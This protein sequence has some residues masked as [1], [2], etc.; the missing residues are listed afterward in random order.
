MRGMWIHLITAGILFAVCATG[1][2]AGTSLGTDWTERPPTDSPFSGVQISTDGS[3]VFAGGNQMLVRNW[4]GDSHF[5]GRAG[6][7][8]S[9]SPDGNYVVVA[10]GA[11]VNLLNNKGEPLWTR[12]MPSTVRA[13]AVSRDGTMIVSTDDNGN[14]NSWAKNGDFYGRATDDRAKKIAISRTGNLIVVTTEGG[15]RYYDG[16]MNLKWAD[17]KSGSLDTYIAIT[18]D[19]ST[20]I[21]A[22]GTRISSHTATGE[23]N[24]MK[25][26][27]KEAI[28]DMACSEDGA[29]IV[30]GSQDN[31]V[32]AVDQY[33]KSHWTYNTGGQWP[34]AVGVSRDASV[35]AAG[36]NDG[37][38]YVLDHGGS[39]LTKRSMGA[40]IQPR[41]LAVSRDGTRIVVADQ[42]HL[43][44]LAVLG[45]TASEGIPTYTSTPLNPAYQ[46]THATAIPTVSPVLT[47]TT[48]EVPPTALP[49]QKSPI[50]PYMA[51]F[52]V[53]GIALIMTRAKK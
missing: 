29:A 8:A 49:T 41:S 37:I 3:T 2:V 18:A 1:T 43:N 25:D 10:L 28:I 53:A 13:V 27:T 22:G 5:G 23:L 4:I 47:L 35:I 6:S 51:V 38:V 36:S 45:D 40:I 46:Y 15:L 16:A 21:T 31:V 24:W 26:V 19:G 34:N 50:G 42:Y 9:M 52:A 44:G 39:L 7:V 11:D 48:E 33:G 12:T 30:V 17:N 32:T 14:Y 20:V